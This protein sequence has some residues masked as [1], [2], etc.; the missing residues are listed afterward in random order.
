MSKKFKT[1]DYFRY[2]KLGK[3]W[4]R[5]VGLQSKLRLRKGGSGLKV[6]I[7]YGT[8]GKHVPAIVKNE[9]DFGQD[10]SSGVI[11]SAGVGSKK[12]LVLAAKAKELGLTIANMKKIRRAS[13]ISAQLQR[14]AEKK[15]KKAEEKKMGFHE[16]VVPQVLQGK[17]KT[18]RLR[19][20]GFQAGDRVAFEDSKT[21]KIFG[22]GK[23]TN[24]QR[25][26]VGLINLNDP[27]H[28]ATY[29][30]VEDLIAA[31]KRHYPDRHVSPEAEA[32][33]YTYEFTLAKAEKKNQ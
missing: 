33:I 21:G 24:I 2:K 3:R 19:D 22:Y 4:R 11:I 15:T 30:K 7:G 31:L 28:G 13:R 5:P 32:F 16:S 12:A 29:A 27:A 6:A 20:H 23:I 9:K 10:C 25:T 8:P 14:K 1:Q 18:Y 26:N 17:T